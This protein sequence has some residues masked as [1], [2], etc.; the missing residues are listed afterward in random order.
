MGKKKNIPPLPSPP[1]P[2]FMGA[3]GAPLTG[4]RLEKA[5][6]VWCKKNLDNDHSK[7]RIKN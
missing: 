5:I 1:P 2:R 7:Y 4:R 6:D 3:H